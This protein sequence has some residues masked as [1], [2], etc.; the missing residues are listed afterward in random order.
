MSDDG[1]FQSI[2]SLKVV[3][4]TGIFR[5]VRQAGVARRTRGDAGGTTG[6]GLLQLSLDSWEAPIV[7]E[8]MAVE[9][10]AQGSTVYRGTAPRAAGS[11][12]VIAIVVEENT[13]T[14]G[15]AVGTAWRTEVTRSTEGSPPDSVLELRRDAD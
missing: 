1:C 7:F 9:R 15:D 8:V 13:R 10:D 11:Q 14:S 12:E 2:P 4:A 6:G 5:G 3:K